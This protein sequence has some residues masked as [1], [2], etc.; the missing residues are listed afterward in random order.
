MSDLLNNRLLIPVFESYEFHPLSGLASSFCLFTLALQ[1]SS[2]YPIP[3]PFHDFVWLIW[4]RFKDLGLYFHDQDASIFMIKMYYWS[5]FTDTDKIVQK[6]RNIIVRS[7]SP[8]LLSLVQIYLLF[9]LISREYNSVYGEKEL[10]T[11]LKVHF[12]GVV[13]S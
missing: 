11:S 1:C 13:R 7:P 8:N 9:W 3:W 10:A 2:H 5:S 12:V 4:P 6:Y